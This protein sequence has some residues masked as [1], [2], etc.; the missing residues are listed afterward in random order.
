MGNIFVKP[1]VE[2]LIEEH[3]KIVVNI[4]HSNIPECAGI[5]FKISKKGIFTSSEIF[6]KVGSIDH[7]LC[8]ILVSN[9]DCLKY[10]TNLAVRLFI[11]S[12]GKYCKD[13]K[14]FLTSLQLIAPKY[15][16][17]LQYYDDESLMNMILEDVLP[18]IYENI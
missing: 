4:L 17:T 13:G 6:F 11:T 14:L 1:Y 15:G 12:C 10:K 8:L 9:E 18:E 3:S 16:D 2:K 7:I 5:K